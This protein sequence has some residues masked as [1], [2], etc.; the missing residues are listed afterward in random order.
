VGA[1]R[2]IAF[3]DL[4]GFTSLN[5]VHGDDTALEVIDTFTEVV[6]GALEQGVGVVKTLGD[7]ILLA[8]DGPEA[9]L[10]TA[11]RVVEALHA[12]DGMPELRGGVHHGP[13]VERDGDVFGATVNLASRLAALADRS[14]LCATPIAAR[15]AADLGLSVE[16]RGEVEVRGVH[17]PVEV[18]VIRPCDGGAHPA[19]RDPVCGMRIVTGPDV[20]RRG[21]A[22][23]CSDDCAARFDR[24]PARYPA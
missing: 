12:V 8:A 6:R 9:A 24:D 19:E 21:A 5:D 1:E 18:F 10:R 3:L 11:T 4:A 22:W 16:P 14:A 23:F 17:D 7:G 2:T 15:T 20:R 13:V